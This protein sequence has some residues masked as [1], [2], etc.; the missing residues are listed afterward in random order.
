MYSPLAKT[1]LIPTSA[2]EETNLSRDT[3]SEGHAQINHAFQPVNGNDPM[4]L[5][6]ATWAKVLNDFDTYK[7][8]RK[9]ELLK[10]VSNGI[11]SDFRAM[12]W[13]LLSTANVS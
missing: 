3:S 8:K 11:P 4:A 12:A 10:L 9:D 5:T 2:E 6:W 13:Q 1:E 7:L